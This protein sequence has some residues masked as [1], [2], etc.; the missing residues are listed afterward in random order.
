M[1]AETIIVVEG[2]AAGW[3][4]VLHRSGYAGD[5]TSYISMKLVSFAG[6]RACDDAN[7]YALGVSNVAKFRIATEHLPTN[8]HIGEGRQTP[9]PVRRPGDMKAAP[10]LLPRERW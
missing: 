5:P 1:A 3:D 9:F 8:L 2:T 6:P 4:V 7:A 10:S